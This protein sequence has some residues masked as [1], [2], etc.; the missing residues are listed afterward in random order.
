ME[1]QGASYE[2]LC[3]HTRRRL[4]LVPLVDDSP[5][6]LCW[7]MPHPAA[8]GAVCSTI[9]PCITCPTRSRCQRGT[10]RSCWASAT[11]TQNYIC[12]PT[13][14]GF[15][16]A[17]VGPQATLFN[18]DDRQIITH[19]LSPNLE[20]KDKPRAT[21]QHSGDTSSGMG[22]ADRVPIPSLIL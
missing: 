7:R 17:F 20:E 14:S 22:N 4:A 1:K 19:F 15:E 13:G 12:L 11:G 9:S 10:G 5:R 3:M 2:T 18:D 21:W 8:T 16:W 6:R